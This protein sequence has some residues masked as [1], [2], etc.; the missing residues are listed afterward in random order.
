L[1]D[2]LGRGGA[3]GVVRRYRIE[4]RAKRADGRFP[5]E[6]GATHGADNYL[7]WFGDGLELAPE[8]EDVARRAFLLE[9]G[10]FLKGEEMAWGTEGV[11]EARRL[12]ADGQV[13]IWSDE[14]WDEGLAVW[15]AL[16]K[17]DG[18]IEKPKL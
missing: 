8:E 7:W 14:L 18:S 17:G 16:R 11:R 1:L 12:K 13:D 5:R 15:D 4:W 2:A 9:L 3:G 6:W 10:R